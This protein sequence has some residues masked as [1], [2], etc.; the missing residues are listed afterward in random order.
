MANIVLE[1]IHLTEQARPIL[2]IDKATLPCDR[3]TAVIGPNG[4]GKT[5][6]LKVIAGLITDPAFAMNTASKNISMVLHQTPFIKMSVWGN[7]IL[8][9]DAI[10][11]L[12]DDQMNDAMNVFSLTHLKNQPATLLSAGE[13]QRLAIARAYL[14]HPELMI[15][16]EPTASLDPNSTL[17]IESKITEL[18]HSGMRFILA[19]HDFAQV[20]RISDHI[21]FIKNG[22]IIEASPTKAFFE[23]PSSEVSQEFI[24]LHV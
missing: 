24:A 14:M 3:I 7:L 21:I 18:A 9:K 15:L 5:T 10:P 4:A 11:S 2:Q 22:Q 1:N 8:L 13:K 16:D 17:F 20:K 12:S 23:S 19:S 6:L